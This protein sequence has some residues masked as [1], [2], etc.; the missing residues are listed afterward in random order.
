[1]VE[2]VLC[3]DTRTEKPDPKEKLEV[4]FSSKPKLRSDSKEVEKFELIFEFSVGQNSKILER[5]GE[6]ITKAASKTLIVHL[7][8]LRSK[9]LGLHLGL[10]T[11]CKSFQQNRLSLSRAILWFGAFHDEI[12]L[13][14]PLISKKKEKKKKEKKL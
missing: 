14:S 2:Y 12:S 10:F 13:Y 1:M 11:T 4:A 9:N 8:E 3:V 5:D 7:E 6:F